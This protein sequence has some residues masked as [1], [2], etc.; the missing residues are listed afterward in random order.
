MRAL[1]KSV[2][3]ESIK[4]KHGRQIA[5]NEIDYAYTLHEKR[6]GGTDET[7]HRPRQRMVSR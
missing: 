3:L 6:C 5:A 2:G 1:Q 4:K 7:S